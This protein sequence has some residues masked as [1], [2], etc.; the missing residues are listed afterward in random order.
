MTVK[1]ECNANA[2]DEFMFPVDWTKLEKSLINSE[3]DIV[4]QYFDVCTSDVHVT[5]IVFEKEEWHDLLSL[6]ILN[7]HGLLLFE[8]ICG[9]SSF[10]TR[11]E[12]LRRFSDIIEM[13][14]DCNLSEDNLSDLFDSGKF[15][16]FVR[17]YEACGVP[18]FCQDENDFWENSEHYDDALTDYMDLEG[19]MNDFIDWKRTI[20]TNSGYWIF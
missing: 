15:S 2:Q 3:Y 16:E 5:G 6:I 8:G 14:D 11:Y 10:T 1:I 17:K 12:F 9:L 18:Y 20:T 19:Y 4:R 13:I 7:D